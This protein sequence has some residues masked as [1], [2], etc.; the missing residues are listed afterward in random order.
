MLWALILLPAICGLLV[1]LPF[2]GRASRVILVSASIAHLL[3]VSSIWLQVRGLMSAPLTALGL[4]DNSLDIGMTAAGGWL[5]LDHLSLL[6]LTII[7]V[8][9]L[10]ASLYSLG[11]LGP[12]R[13]RRIIDYRDEL[14]LN[15]QPDAVFISCLLLFLSSTTLV[16]TARHM[17]IMWIAIET[18]TLAT[19]PLIFFHRNARSLEAA[20]K[21]LLLCSVGIAMAMLGNFFLALATARGGMEETGLLIPDLLAVAPGMSPNWLKA[22]WLLMLVGYGTKMGLAPMHS[23]LPDAHSE[24]PSPVSA[25]LSGALLNCAFLAILRML[26]ILDASGMGDFGRHTLIGFGLLSILWAAMLMIPQTDYKR[27]LAYSSVEHMGILATGIGIGGL[28]TGG[29]LFHAVNHSLTKGALFLIA[30][31]IL[32]M[33]KT[34]NINDV[35]GLLKTAPVQGVLWVA[36]LLAITGAPPF[37]LFFSELQILRGAIQA[38]HWVV[39][40]LFLA[41]LSLAFAAMLWALVRM[42]WGSPIEGAGPGTNH[43]HSVFSEAV[44]VVLLLAVMVLGLWMPG[45]LAEVIELATRGLR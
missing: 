42:A 14:H 16:T 11:Y 33:F 17:G 30:G 1:F 34:K 8:L 24:A 36:G 5:A 4:P 23:W 19:T 31:N 22:A 41:G 6:F 27:M 18:T 12:E 43:T 13:K 29:S 2:I 26:G 10:G 25:L 21:Y 7:S 9:F 32:A 20:W 44:P 35:A 28:A 37:G 45:P 15:N 40:L 39:T 38:G 3:M